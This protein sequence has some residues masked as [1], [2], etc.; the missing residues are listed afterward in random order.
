[1]AI[2]THPDKS[3]SDQTTITL[4]KIHFIPGA[5]ILSSRQIYGL[6]GGT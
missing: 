3:F 2:N 5:V 1:M 6:F 4:T